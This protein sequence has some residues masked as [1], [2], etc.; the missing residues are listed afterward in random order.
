MLGKC[1]PTDL[2]LQSLLWFWFWFWDR[3]SLCLA[4]WP[5]GTRILFQPHSVLV[6]RACTTISSCP[7]CAIDTV[8]VRWCWSWSVTVTCWTWLSRAA[9]RICGGEYNF[10]LVVLYMKCQSQVPSRPGLWSDLSPGPCSCPWSCTA[11]VSLLS[12]SWLASLPALLT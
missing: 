4:G 2:R 5:G 1:S 6:S 11:H 8:D 3:I 7:L 10:A 9:S 12:Q